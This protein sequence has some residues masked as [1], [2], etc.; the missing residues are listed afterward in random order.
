MQHKYL[1]QARVKHKLARGISIYVSS[2]PARMDGYPIHGQT[3][4]AMK[5][6]GLL[7]KSGSDRL[8]PTAKLRREMAKEVA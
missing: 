8:V 7:K 3:I 4:K 6:R 2:T 5:A 1:S